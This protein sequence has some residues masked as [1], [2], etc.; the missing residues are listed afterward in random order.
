MLAGRVIIAVRQYDPTR[1]ILR[2]AAVGTMARTTP[3][4]K[5]LDID[6]IPRREKRSIRH[7]DLWR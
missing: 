5:V 2:S 7:G 6:R 3:H 1:P 4:R